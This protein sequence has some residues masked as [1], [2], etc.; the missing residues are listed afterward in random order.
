MNTRK[1]KRIL[2]PLAA[3]LMLAFSVT[4]SAIPITGSIGFGGAFA[5]TGGSDLSDATGIN[6]LTTFVL[7]GSGVYG[8]I[9]TFTGASF[10]DFVFNPPATPV[11]PLWSLSSGGT[12][13]SFDLGDVSIDFQSAASL[14][15]TGTGTLMATGFDDTAGDW[16]FSGNS[17]GNIVFTFSTI[18]TATGVS[19]PG[20]MALMSLGVLLLAAVQ[21][22]RQF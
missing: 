2:A 16:V 7:D 19:E 20:M 3:S 10:T 6:F 4:A 14:N 15:L 17:G 9:P 18:S 13:Y 1:T 8:G 12:D 21:R 11:A 5:P 22:R